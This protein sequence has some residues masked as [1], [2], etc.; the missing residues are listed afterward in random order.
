MSVCVCDS[1]T[2]VRISCRRT[3]ERNLRKSLMS[4]DRNWTRPS[5]SALLSAVIECL[6]N[7]RLS[8][9]L[10]LLLFINFLLRP[11]RGVEYCDQPICLSVCLSVCVFVCLSVCLSVCLQA[12]RWNRWNDLHEILCADPLSPWLG[13]PLAALHY[14]VY[15]WFYG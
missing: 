10:L 5:K 1:L 7:S 3:R 8:Q 13:P 14:I 12:Y 9:L 15:F 6:S 4:I 2:V 11:G